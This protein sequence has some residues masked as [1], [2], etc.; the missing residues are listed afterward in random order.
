MN[1]KNFCF[2]ILIFCFLEFFSRY[3]HIIFPYED[4]QRYGVTRSVEFFSRR[5]VEEYLQKKDPSIF[6]TR[7]FPLKINGRSAI[8]ELFQ[9]QKIKIAFF[10]T[11][12]LFESV[13]MNKA[14]PE[15]LKKFSHNKIHVDNF[16]YY[17]TSFK[18]L[19]KK[20]DSLCSTRRFY[21]LLVIQL[22]HYNPLESNGGGGGGR[23]PR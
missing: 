22:S 15:F 8:G 2:Y 11:S 6:T 4:H 18:I 23:I 1:R 17:D 14:W 5:N 9:G 10:G 12:A 16:A 7:V 13:P 19:K 20:L 21:N 3:G